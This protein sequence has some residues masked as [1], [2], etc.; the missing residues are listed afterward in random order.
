M[1][2]TVLGRPSV[3]PGR[4]LPVLTVDIDAVYRS[5]ARRRARRARFV[6]GAGI[7][8]GGEVWDVLDA[9]QALREQPN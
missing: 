2:C 3:R 8:G 1:T 7:K 5:L 6:L 4:G 9:T